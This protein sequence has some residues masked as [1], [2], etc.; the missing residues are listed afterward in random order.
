MSVTAHKKNAWWPRARLIATA[1]FLSLGIWLLYKNARTVEWADVRAALKAYPWPVLMAAAALA[2]CSHVLYS[3]YDLLGRYYTRHPLFTGTVMKITFICYAFTLNLGSL[4]G[5]VALRLRLYSRHGVSAGKA[6]RI[7]AMSMLTNWLGYCVL[8]GVAFTLWPLALPASWGLHD[9]ALPALGL[10]L[11]LIAA[12]YL[13]TCAVSLTH[14]LRFRGHTLE[15]P[16]LPAALLQVVMSCVNWLLIAGIVY[17]L[18]PERIGFNVVLSVLLIAAIAGVVTQLPAGLGVLEAVFLALL[19][20]QMATGQLLA[21][22]L[23]YRAIYY[24]VPLVVALGLYLLT[25]ARQRTAL[26]RVQA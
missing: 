19:T 7:M 26:Q 21:A 18:L 16:T 25:E 8:A 11:L 15:L 10:A 23:A 9:D 17:V 3:T 22:L 14:E 13:F 12:I 4:I 1:F 24:I 20:P 6:T 5:G 2:A